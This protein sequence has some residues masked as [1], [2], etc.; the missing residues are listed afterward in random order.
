MPERPVTIKRYDNR[1]LYSP[2]AGAYLSLENLAAMA[3][4]DEEFVVFDARTNEDVTSA[5]LR[6]IILRQAIYG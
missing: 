6:Q 2:A 4:N 1:R 3:K 5:A